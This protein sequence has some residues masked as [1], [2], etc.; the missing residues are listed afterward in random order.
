MSDDKK[1]PAGPIGLVGG[2]LLGTLLGGVVG[3]KIGHGNSGATVVG[4]GLGAVTLGLIGV[5]AS[6]WYEADKFVGGIEDA[7]GNR[8]AFDLPSTADVRDM[9]TLAPAKADTAGKPAGVGLI[10][11]FP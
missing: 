4:A 1:L 3:H 6:Y 2:S 9:F 10:A 5:V 7:S 8:G 11:R